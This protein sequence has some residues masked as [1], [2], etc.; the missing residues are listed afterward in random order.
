MSYFTSIG[1]IKFDTEVSIR[2]S[3]VVTG[4]KNN[5]S[6]G[7]DLPDQT[8]HSRRRHDAILTNHNTTHLRNS[9]T[10]LN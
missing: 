8:R 2:S 5:P 10:P 1:S 3:R 4:C 7:F 6:N 9:T